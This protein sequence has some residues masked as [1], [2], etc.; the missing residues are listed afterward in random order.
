MLQPKLPPYDIREWKAKPFPVRMRMICEAWATQGYGTPPAIYTVY[1]FKIALLYVGGWCFFCSFTP[2]L[3]SWRAIASWAFS[4]IAFQKAVLWTMAYE[5]LGLGCG[6]GPLTGRY[7]PPLGGVLYYLRPGTTKLPFIPGIPLFGGNRRARLDVALYVAHY[8]FMLRALMAP[9]LTPALLAPTFVLLPILGLTDK[10]IY[11]ISRA[12]H[13]FTALVCFAFAEYWIPGCKVLW[14]A[15]WWWAATS[16][17]NRHFPSVVCVMMS[18]SPVVPVW[19]RK[20]LYKSFPDDLRPGP[21][22]EAMAHA[23]TVTEYTFPLVLLLS[24][25]GFVTA[26]ALVVMLGFHTFITSNIPMGVPIEWNVIMVYGAFFLFG[27]HADASVLTLRSAPLTLTAFL[28]VVLFLVPLVGNFVPSRV[29]FL[30][31]MRYYAGNWG[32]SV[33][34]FR[35]KSVEK[36]DRL[37]KVSP[38]LRD[39]LRVIIKEDDTI[40]AVMS[41]VPA[42]RSMHLHGRV[43]H[44][45]VPRAVDDIDAYEWL[46]GEIIAGLA[47]GWNFGDGHLHDTRLLRAIQEQCHF[48]DGELRV[49]MIESQ[50]MLGSSM[51][52]TIADAAR[53]VLETGETRISTLLDRL[54]WPAAT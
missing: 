30:S 39:Q 12:E 38:L 10:T 54:P 26:A 23:G 15:I 52:W 6:S 37:V 28:F 4:P 45:L 7:V 47:L 49:I 20:K 44:D 25:G 11:L 2:G 43:L 36:L 29:S 51:A 22:A 1:I 21:L 9:A 35:G 31:S 18:N 3:G 41:R 32:F 42:F 17:L 46:D 53:G 27:H 50:P 14:L 34:L 8:A 19:F 48:E 13:H 5:G 33:W 24:H 40:D 16:K